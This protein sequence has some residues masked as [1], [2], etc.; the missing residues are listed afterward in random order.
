MIFDI[1]RR[2]TRRPVASIL[3]LGTF[4]STHASIILPADKIIR[5]RLPSRAV[6]IDRSEP[7]TPEWLTVHCSEPLHLIVIGSRY[8]IPHTKNQPDFGT[9]HP[10][11]GPEQV[12]S[13]EEVYRFDHQVTFP[14]NSFSSK[15]GSAAFA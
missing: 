15:F 6:P 7:T 1:K 13:I 3:A 4:L 12:S 5:I 2:I 9:I 11:K 10:A 8:E 14:V